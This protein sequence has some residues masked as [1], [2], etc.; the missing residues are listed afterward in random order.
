MNPHQ[1]YHLISRASLRDFIIG[2]S[3]GLTVPFALAAG[4]SG[5]VNSTG[6]IVTAG[7]A[8][9]VA[10]AI[11]M[12]LGGY[13]ATKTERDYYESEERREHR[14]VQQVPHVETQ[15]VED[16]FRVYG[17]PEPQLAAV[18]GAICDHPQRWVDFMMRFELGLEKPD[19]RRLLHSPL[20][21]GGAYALGGFVPLI[22]YMLMVRAHEALQ[23]SVLVSMA[24][25]AA[26]GA[27]KG[28]VTGH[29]WFTSAWQTTA[30][31]G[32]AAGCAFYIAK[33]VS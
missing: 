17:V 27:F 11:S 22:P 15:E 24:A 16:I 8:E 9:V 28:K 29:N 12:G 4:L 14:E 6:I 7:I 30:I 3:D 33:L 25:L 1:E 5:A 18:V 31:G 2:M 20:I 19:P 10:G 32:L 13:L 21:I 23:M 26:F